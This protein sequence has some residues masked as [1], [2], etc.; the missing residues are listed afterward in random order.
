MSI[1]LT[2]IKEVVLLYKVIKNL[3]RLFNFRCAFAYCYKYESQEAL[4][5]ATSDRRKRRTQC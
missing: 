3:D 5:Q 1:G 4:M 2:L